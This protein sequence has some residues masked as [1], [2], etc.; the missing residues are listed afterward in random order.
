MAGTIESTNCKIREKIET[1]KLII[2]Q[3][4]HLTTILDSI[5]VEYKEVLVVKSIFINLMY[6][7][8]NELES[9]Y[10]LSIVHILTSYYSTEKKYNID[11][12]AMEFYRIIN[13]ENFVSRIDEY[14]SKSEITMDILVSCYI[15]R[16]EKLKGR[17]KMITELSPT[18]DLYPIVEKIRKHISYAHTITIVLDT[19]KSNYEIC[20]CGERM[21]VLPSSSELYCEKCQEIK[22]LYGTASEDLENYGSENNKNRHGKYDPGRHFKFWMERLQAKQQKTFDEEHIAAIEGVVKRDNIVLDNVYEMRGIL[23]ETKLTRYNDHA[24]LLMKILTGVSPPQLSFEML[25]RFSIKFNKTIEILEEIKDPS[26]NRPYY[27]YF[28]YKIAEDEA[29]IAKA[30]N[31][32]DKYDELQRLLRYIHLQADETVRKNDI[33]YKRICERSQEDETCSNDDQLHF[34]PT[35]RPQF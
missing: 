15:K 13:S 2:E 1:I 12:T 34:K 25:R 7:D 3:I 33:L 4:Q 8:F 22:N 35:E 5:S 23:K 6:G 11:E 9:M 29:E 10:N 14:L 18:D 32:K 16:N 17:K 24:P 28:I 26:G 30:K 19:K 27:P 21:S 20:S 31:N